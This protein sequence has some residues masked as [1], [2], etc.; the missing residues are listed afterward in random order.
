MFFQGIYPGEI[1]RRSGGDPGAGGGRRATGGPTGKGLA[2]GPTGK[3]LAG[4][5]TGKGLAG[6]PTE[7]AGNKFL[8]WQ[9]WQTVMTN[10]QKVMTK[11]P[12]Y[13][14]RG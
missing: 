14:Y 2:G 6:G 1:G 12:T 3:G 13:T 7:E 5:P 8:S 9:C 10:W 4:G 11:L